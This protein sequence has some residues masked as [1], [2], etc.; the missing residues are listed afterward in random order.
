[1][2]AMH[3]FAFLVAATA[4]VTGAAAAPSP[5]NIVFVLMDDVGWGDFSYQN[6]SARQYQPGAGGT[7]WRPNPPR[8]PHIDALAHGPHSLVFHRFYAGSAVCSPTRASMLSGRTSDREC[9]SVVEGCGQQP[10]W[11]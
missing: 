2:M 6:V 5:P 1:M 9:I 7:R 8:T 11:M 3:T 10:A 4:A